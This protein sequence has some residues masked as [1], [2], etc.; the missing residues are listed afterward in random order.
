MAEWPEL[1]LVPYDRVA[2]ASTTLPATQTLSIM[3][4]KWEGKII[5]W[6]NIFHLLDRILCSQ[7]IFGGR[8]IVKLGKRGKH[9]HFSSGFFQWKLQDSCCWGLIEYLIQHFYLS[10]NLAT[11]PLAF[12]SDLLRV[13]LSKHSD[14]GMLGQNPAASG[15]ARPSEKQQLL[16]RHESRSHWS[17]FSHHEKS[18]FL[19]W[20]IAY[21]AFYS[22]GALSRGETKFQSPKFQSKQISIFFRVLTAALLFRRKCLEHYE[23]GSTVQLE[24]ERGRDRN[25]WVWRRP[26]SCRR[27]ECRVQAVTLPFHT[28]LP[29][30]IAF[31]S[32]GNSQNSLN[33]IVYVFRNLCC[34]FACFVSSYLCFLSAEFRVL[35]TWMN[36]STILPIGCYVFCTCYSN[37]KCQISFVELSCW[38]WGGCSNENLTQRRTETKSLGWTKHRVRASFWINSLFSHGNWRKY[39][40]C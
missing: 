2:L 25:V 9:S 39:I 34:Y 35:E 24:V 29:F 12:Y 37:C 33:V 13:A 11:P 27:K 14:P 22:S 5:R 16:G 19:H 32:S 30:L 40:F 17:S 1:Q 7:A 18:K 31:L 15:F 38:F 4:Q 23:R 8:S 21:F 28:L 36:P 26:P 6:R 10:L 20:K 3:F